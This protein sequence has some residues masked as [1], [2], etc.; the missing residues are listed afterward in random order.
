MTQMALGLDAEY[1]VDPSVEI[2]NGG[3]ISPT[4]ATGTTISVPV[5][6]RSFGTE[7]EVNGLAFEIAYDLDYVSNASF[8]FSDTWINADGLSFQFQRAAEGAIRIAVTRLG[9]NPINDDGIIGTLD[10]VIIE[11]LVGLL[12]NT[13]ERVPFA[14]VEGVNVVDGEYH[15][16]LT[17]SHTLHFSG[18]QAV[19]NSENL[20][21][22]QAFEGVVFPN[23]TDGVFRVEASHSFNKIDLLAANGRSQTI[24]QGHSLT[25]WS[26]TIELDLPVGMYYLRL[27]GEKGLCLLPVV[28][29]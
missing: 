9:A 13:P 17:A 19:S 1:G 26:T 28:I 18:N 10:L 5:R 8:T 27:S 6:F 4:I 24:Y 14:S 15:P 29:R 20:A 2:N 11:D 23:P 3:D 25:R 12:P 22:G 16:I 21:S 7:T